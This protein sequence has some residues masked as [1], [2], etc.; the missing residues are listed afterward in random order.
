MEKETVTL[1]FKHYR[2]VVLNIFYNFVAYLV[3]KVV[4]IILYFKSWQEARSRH[5]AWPDIKSIHSITKLPEHLVFVIHPEDKYLSWTDIAKLVFW[6]TI[7]NVENISLYDT[8]GRLLS[9]F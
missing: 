8:E 1:H 6:S 2:T 4:S 3:H 5:L 9:F 7:A